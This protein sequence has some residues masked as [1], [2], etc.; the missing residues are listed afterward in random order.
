MIHVRHAI[1]AAAAGLA[2]LGQ[3]RLERMSS[4][5]LPAF[6]EVKE[7]VRSGRGIFTKRPVQ[8]GQRI[9]ASRAYAFGVGGVTAKDVQSVCHHCLVNVDRAPLVCK[10]CRVVGYCS[11]KCQRAAKALHTLE[12]SNWK[13]FVPSMNMCTLSPL[14]MTAQSAGHPSMH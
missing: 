11:K 4:I 3:A 10:N 2:R 5:H 6:L 9:F 14:L 13:N 12:F 1:K 8:R 7:T